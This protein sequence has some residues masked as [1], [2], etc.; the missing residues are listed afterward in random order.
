M[1]RGS[2]AVAARTNVLIARD[3]PGNLNHVEELVR[4]LDTQ[5][6]Q[7]LVEARI[8]EAPSQYL[9]DVGIQWGGD[10]SFTQA[11]GNPP[12]IA[13]PSDITAS[14]GN[15]DQNSPTAGLSPFERTVP[16]PNFAVNLP[17][18][19]GT[20]AGGAIGLNPPR[21]R[22]RSAVTGYASF[23]FHRSNIS[24]QVCSA[25]SAL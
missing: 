8:V 15:Y 21:A 20:G 14:G 17:A 3:I 19:V 12:G 1:V 4:S 11:T 2:I 22:L 13:F 6:P 16:Q 9:R 23:R 7:V 10:V 25:A 24:V 18:A 5:T